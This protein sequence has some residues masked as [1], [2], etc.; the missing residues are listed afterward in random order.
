MLVS[1]II[2]S[3]ECTIN[4]ILKLATMFSYK[5]K[6]S[7]NIDPTPSITHQNDEDDEE[8]ETDSRQR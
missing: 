2:Y 3:D 1:F 5:S 4:T 7:Y 6:G 8:E